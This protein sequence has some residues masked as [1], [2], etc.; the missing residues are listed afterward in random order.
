MTSW[1]VPECSLLFVSFHKSARQ[2]CSVALPVPVDEVL[3][4]RR[5]L[6]TVGLVRRSP[7]D[8]ELLEIGK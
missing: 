1:S 5:R 8:W 4:A 6:L 7:D 2:R 3:P